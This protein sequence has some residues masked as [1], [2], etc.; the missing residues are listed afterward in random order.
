MLSRSVVSSTAAP[1]NRA[2]IMSEGCV[3][4]NIT[5][6]MYTFQTLFESSR[7]HLEPMFFIPDDQDLMTSRHECHERGTLG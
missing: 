6:R 7:L 3:H 1:C 5:S 2:D 4:M